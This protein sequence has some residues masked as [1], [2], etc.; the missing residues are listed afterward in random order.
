MNR[1]IY[2]KIILIGFGDIY[3]K[4]L[5][6]LV[7]IQA[8]WDYRLEVIEHE[9]YPMS[10]IEG[11]CEENRI[12]YHKLPEREELN[13][14]FN[15]I[16]EKTLIISAGN[17]YLFPGKLPEK[18]NLT[19]INFHN[20][21]LPKYPGKNAS[22]WA[23]FEGEKRTG[24]TWH[25]VNAQDDAK[26]ILWQGEC[27][28]LPDI[29]AYELD[30]NIMDIAYQGFVEIADGLLKGTIMGK[31]QVVSLLSHQIYNSEDVPRGGIV[32][33]SDSTD[34]IYRVLRAMDYGFNP[35]F[36]RLRIRD[37]EGRIFTIKRY[38]K[39]PAKGI[40]EDISGKR[41]HLRL[42]DQY[43]IKLDVVRGEFVDISYDFSTPN[44]CEYNAL[45]KAVGWDPIGESMYNS[46]VKAS[47][48]VTARYKDQVI[49]MSRMITDGGLVSL[50][51]DV[52]VDPQFQA[53]GI[54]DVLVKKLLFL[55]KELLDGSESGYV[56]VLASKGNDGFYNQMGFMAR[57][58][59]MLGSG[60]TMKIMGGKIN[61]FER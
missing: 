39:I 26:E 36:Q 28:I 30:R 23:I 59:I 43:V 49:G 42:N 13:C 32:N 45:R 37:D 41:Y 16:E 56:N 27:E 22:S 19:V 52:I 33:I 44:Y 55:H 17:K 8:S 34:Y 5:K 54:G 51:A 48:F 14:F 25:I 29:K 2:E 12:L 35:I 4:L 31:E 38:R 50:I 60:M 11:I 10:R 21:L 9:Y 7:S 57:P 15:S 53:Q 47:V 46:A 18:S 61:K 58:N 24:A 20:A 6:Y 1:S 3:K 40:V